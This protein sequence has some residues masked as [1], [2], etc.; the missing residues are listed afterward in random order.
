MIKPHRGQPLW[1]AF[2]LHRISGLLLAIFLPFHFFLL[3]LALEQSETMDG[4]LRWSDYPLVKIAEFGLVFLLAVHMFGGLRLLA[5]EFLPWS[6]R[7]KTYAAL[8]VAASLFVACV[9]LLNAVW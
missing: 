6:P 2:L 8:A 3:G 7:Q 4:L 9:F 5:L 1:I